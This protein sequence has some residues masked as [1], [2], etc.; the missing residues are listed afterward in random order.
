MGTAFWDPDGQKYGLFDV[1]SFD[2]LES[3]V[4]SGLGGGSLIYA[5]VM[6]RKDEKSFVHEDPLP[7]GGYESWPVTLADLDPHYDAVEKMLGVTPYPY[8]E[9][10]KTRAMQEAAEG[11][12][13]PWQRAPL[14]VSFA[15]RPDAAPAPGQ[16]LVD[17]PYPN[18]HGVPRRTCDLAGACDIGCNEGAKNSL[19]HTYL[20]AAQHQKADLRT[21]CEVTT[22]RPHARGYEVRY[23][24]H[25]PNGSRSPKECRITATRVVLGAGT[26]GT[27]YLMLRSRKWLRGL[28][29]SLGSRFSGNGD[30]L[31]FLMPG[32]KERI[33]DASTGPVITSVMSGRGRNGRDFLVQD[34]GFP[35]FVD[36]MIETVGPSQAFRTLGFAGDWLGR[37]FRRREHPR[38]SDGVADLIGNGSV[39]AGSLPL[40]GMGRDVP[41]GVMSLDG[42]RLAVDWTM[43]TSTPF[44]D[45]LLATMDDI[46]DELGTE[47]RENPL[48]HLRRA[49]TVHPLGGAPMGHHR[50]TGVCDDHGQ[51]FGHPHLY[52]ADGAAMPGPVGAN[53]SLTIAAFADRVADGI[54]RDLDVRVSPP[55]GRPV[56]GSTPR[57][58][59]SFTEEMRGHLT[60]DATE[61]GTGAARETDVT[62]HLT[63]TIDDVHRFVTEP[64]HL[65]TVEGRIESEAL[66]WSRT[67]R[68]GSFNLF[69][70]GSDAGSRRMTYR[71]VFDDAEG[72]TRTLVGHKEVRDDPGLDAWRDTTTLFARLLDGEVEAPPPDG[73]DGERAPAAGAGEL[74][75]AWA[76]LMIQ[77]TTFRTT[78]P[79]GAQA[80]YRFGRFFFGQVWDVYGFGAPEA[81]E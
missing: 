67:V 38:M 14:A 27:T 69:V 41:D 9:T 43:E 61:S 30:L 7:R 34:G 1:W 44:F 53:P 63:I 33:F 8:P 17:S 24:R 16:T 79:D 51:V 15:P 54:L 52:V 46:S 29:A 22:I 10:P 65:A 74:R 57:T 70:P 5:N 6:L 20:S 64:D 3:I 26:Y 31:A 42:D 78:G 80:L 62:V 66:G 19:D 60:L 12:R 68:E 18:L 48:S 35:A 36:W 32:A 72:N 4:S 75:I 50:T 2:G 58:G 73:P 23:L 49:V 40:L 25:R 45:Q 21:L 11:L 47:L 77:L 71:L 56:R 81:G 13:L 39:S 37:R 76:D 59:L 28:S 55:P